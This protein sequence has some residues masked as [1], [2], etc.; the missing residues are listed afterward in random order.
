MLLMGDAD[1]EDIFRFVVVTVISLF[2]CFFFWL[3]CTCFAL[4]CLH[5]LT[6]TCARLRLRLRFR[7]RS[8]LQCLLL[9]LRL[10]V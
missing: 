3:V 2:V 5:C 10:F 7:L 6:C 8:L 4:L 9:W 1:V